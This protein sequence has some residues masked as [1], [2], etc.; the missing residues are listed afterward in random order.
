MC[1]E[2]LCIPRSTMPVKFTLMADILFIGE[3][4]HEKAIYIA[5]RIVIQKKKIVVPT[6]K[7]EKHFG[8]IKNVEIKI[9]PKISVTVYNIPHLVIYDSEKQRCRECYMRSSVHKL[10]TKFLALKGAGQFIIM[11]TRA[12]HWTVSCDSVRHFVLSVITYSFSLMW[13]HKADLN[14]IK[15]HSSNLISMWNIWFL[16]RCGEK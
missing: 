13:N 1:R 8:F 11:F 5:K 10:V 7:L 12:S 4:I 15:I 16:S 3:S 2:L 6:F 14:F 9:I